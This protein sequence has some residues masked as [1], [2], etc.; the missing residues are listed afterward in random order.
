MDLMLA[1]RPR[2]V[3]AVWEWCREESLSPG[4]I[5]VSGTMAERPVFLQRRALQGFLVMMVMMRY[6]RNRVYRST[7]KQQ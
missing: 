3:V 4:S 1:D 6:N 7:L 5:F 2:P